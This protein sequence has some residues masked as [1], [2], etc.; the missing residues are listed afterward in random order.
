MMLGQN[1]KM[2]SE[3]SASELVDG[4]MLPFASS[5]GEPLAAWTFRRR[6]CMSPMIGALSPPSKGFGVARGLGDWTR[7]FGE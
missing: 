1:R 6:V 2:F 5:F 7:L 3:A 4:S